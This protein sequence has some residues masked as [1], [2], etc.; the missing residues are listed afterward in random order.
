M[1]GLPDIEYLQSSFTG[2]QTVYTT[3]YPHP[4]SDRLIAEGRRLLVTR[5]AQPHENRCYW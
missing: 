3:A 2:H 5:Q 4:G 1:D